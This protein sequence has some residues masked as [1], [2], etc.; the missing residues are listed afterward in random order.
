[1]NKH[2]E[3][4]VNRREEIVRRWFDAWL[5]A[6]APDFAAIFAE[7]AVYIESWGP[8]YRGLAKIRHWFTEWNTRGRVLRWEIKQMLHG[9]GQTMVEWYFQDRMDSGAEE[10]FDGVSLIRWTEEGKI[11]RLQ[12]FGCNCRRYDPYV[13]G[14]APRFSGEKAM[15][16]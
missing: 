1:M 14:A 5:R 6:E 10:I 16:F 8:E 11:A 7:D 15:W 12:E 2:G 9:G 13:Q 4:E 3:A